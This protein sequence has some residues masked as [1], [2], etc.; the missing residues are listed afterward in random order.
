MSFRGTRLAGLGWAAPERRVSSAEIEAQLGLESGWIER[1]TG[2]RERRWASDGD[3]L[4]G[5][6]VAAGEQA[7]TDAGIDRADIG[8]TLL[9]TSTPDQLLPPTGPLVA[10]RLGLARSGAVDLAGACGG[11]LYAL[12][13]AEGHVRLT[14]KAALV[15][16]ANILSR[17]I[18]PA[19]RA[20]SVLFADAAGA[21]VVAPDA[22]PSRG[23]RASAL[24]ADGAGYGLVGIPAGG[25]SAPFAA[26][27]PIEDTLMAIADGRGLF[28]EAVRL[29]VDCS[30]EVL[31]QADVTPQSV[32]RFVPHQANARIFAAVGSKLGVRDEAMAS[33]IAEFGNSSAATIPLTLALSHQARP[34]TAGETLLLAAAGAGMTGGALLIRA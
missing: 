21:V 14:G 11:F 1:R 27:L 15:I 8:L 32:D 10:H 17:R 24:A 16:G 6:A 31:A 13:L 30:R 28:L 25:S 18:N 7:L 19:E 12:A 29:M 20:S 9:A 22:D 2:I 33:S 26:D 23:M 3:T 34:I 5:L 4:S